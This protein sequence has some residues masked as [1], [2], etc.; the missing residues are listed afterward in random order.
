MGVYEEKIAQQLLDGRCELVIVGA[1]DAIPSYVR[2]KIYS[3]EKNTEDY[4]EYV[5]RTLACDIGKKLLEEGL[6]SIEKNGDFII[7]R[8]ELV[9][10]HKQH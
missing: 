9:V 3:S 2:D 8:L 4:V 7:A 6:I 5:S 1:T 10:K